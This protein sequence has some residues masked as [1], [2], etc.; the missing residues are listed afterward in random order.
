MQWSRGKATYS[1]SRTMDKEAIW[2]SPSC[3]RPAA[4]GQASLF[5]EDAA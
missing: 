3:E 1:G 4:S 5:E 2:F